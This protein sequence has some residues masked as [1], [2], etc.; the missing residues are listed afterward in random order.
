MT[1]E[2][3]QTLLIPTGIFLVSTFAAFAL[4]QVKFSLRRRR[5]A[6]LRPAGPILLRTRDGIFRT[7][8]DR[9]ENGNWIISAPLSRN[10][11]VAVQ[12]GEEVL[13]DAPVEGGALLFRTKILARDP[14]THLYTIG[15]PDQL[16]RAERRETRRTREELR[17]ATLNGSP[18][19]ILNFSSEGALVL[20]GIKLDNGDLT[21]LEVNGQTILGFCLDSVFESFDG[22]MGSLTR[23]KFQEP[24]KVFDLR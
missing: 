6:Q 3:F 16:H 15:L 4:F 17:S 5:Y 12:P 22:V 2:I 9:F 23:I 11:Y 18:A 14:R 20:S 24:T 1:S 7:H 8:F 19:R 10:N 21:S 13:V